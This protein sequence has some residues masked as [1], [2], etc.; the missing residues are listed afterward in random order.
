MLPTMIEEFAGVTAKDARVR[1]EGLVPALPHPPILKHRLIAIK[2]AMARRIWVI[3]RT[4][5]ALISKA[6]SSLMPASD[7]LSG[8]KSDPC[9][10]CRGSP[11]IIAAAIA[12]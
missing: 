10:R 1:G 4:A 8:A 3:N 7:C 6:S 5:D 12:D 2:N 9:L 11:A